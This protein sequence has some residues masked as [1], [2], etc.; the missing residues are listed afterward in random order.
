MGKAG[1]GGEC[2]DGD[3]GDEGREIKKDDTSPKNVSLALATKVVMRI[4]RRS[5]I[6]GSGVFMGEIEAAVYALPVSFAYA[7]RH[8]FIMLV[9]FHSFVMSNDHSNFK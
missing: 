8:G 4:A 2:K 7:R 9:H 1:V 3:N 5:R 6:V